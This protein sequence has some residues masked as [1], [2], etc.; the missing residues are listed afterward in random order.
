MKNDLPW[1]VEFTYE[2]EIPVGADFNGEWLRN[3]EATRCPFL[4]LDVI[5]D[6]E[7]IYRGANLLEPITAT[8]AIIETKVYH[9]LLDAFGNSLDTSVWYPAT[10]EA[11]KV[12]YSIYYNELGAKEI[13]PQT[14]IKDDITVYPNPSYR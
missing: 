7:T 14:E 1:R 9:L 3:S 5:E 13:L 12:A 6:H 4:E 10:P 2:H 11:V 8:E